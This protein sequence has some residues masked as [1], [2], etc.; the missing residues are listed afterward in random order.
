[1]SASILTA[2]SAQ[3]PGLIHAWYIIAK[4]PEPDYEYEPVPR[5]RGEGGGNVTYVFVRADDRQR[6]QGQPK[7]QSGMN[8]GTAGAPGNNDNSNNNG[9]SSSSAP[10]PPQQRQ[11]GQTPSPDNGEGPSDGGPAPPSYAQVVAGDHKVQSQE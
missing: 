1:M 3:I 10:P 2:P 8:Y 5:D 9:A 4:F 7:L 11:Q 6:R